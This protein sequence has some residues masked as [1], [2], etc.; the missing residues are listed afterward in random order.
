LLVALALS[1]CTPSGGSGGTGDAGGGNGGSGASGSGMG[2]AGTGGSDTGGSGMGGSGMGGSGSGGSGMGGSGMGG[3]GWD[4]GAPGVTAGPIGGFRV[5]RSG[6]GEQLWGRWIPVEDFTLESLAIK[7]PD[8]SSSKIDY[9]D[10]PYFVKNEK[11]VFL[12][13]DSGMNGAG[14]YGLDFTV[15]NPDGS[16]LTHSLEAQTGALF[17]WPGQID[18]VSARNDVADGLQVTIAPAISGNVARMFLYAADTEC[19]I[20][21]NTLLEAAPITA[22]IKTEISVGATGLSAGKGY[23]LLLQGLDAARNYVYYATLDVTAP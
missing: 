21:S 15:G 22:G 23:V 16:T 1:G 11:T 18:F 17:R 12:L 9:F 3:S 7:L 6:C 14:T 10:Q 2:G 20:M 13:R 5:F 4:E 19:L 8:G